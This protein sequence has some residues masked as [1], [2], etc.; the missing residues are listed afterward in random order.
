MILFRPFFFSFFSQQA[1]IMMAGSMCI[2]Q[3]SG[4]SATL[5]SGAGCRPRRAGASASLVR[6]Q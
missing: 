1:F 4:D 5:S 3:L 6:A 2:M